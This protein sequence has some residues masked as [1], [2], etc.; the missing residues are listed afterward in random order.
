MPTLLH[1]VRQSSRLKIRIGPKEESKD[2]SY[3]TLP[4]ARSEQETLV[5]IAVVVKEDIFV[6]EESL[7]LS[8]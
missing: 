4:Q 1:S 3:K 7:A 6:P 2:L 8:N 5:R